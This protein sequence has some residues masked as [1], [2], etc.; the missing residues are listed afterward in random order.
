MYDMHGNIVEWI[1]DYVSGGSTGADG[2]P[3]LTQNGTV[4]IS[5]DASTLSIYRGVKGGNYASVPRM[6]R[7][8]AYGKRAVDQSTMGAG[9]RLVRTIPNPVQ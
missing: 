7:I 1:H 8:A 3:A 2:W 5:G 9:F 4:D 6:T